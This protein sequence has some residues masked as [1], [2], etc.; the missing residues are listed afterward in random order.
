M[1]A[2]M[3]TNQKDNDIPLVFT[4]GY[5]IE[6]KPGGRAVP[7]GSLPVYVSR[8]RTWVE[9]LENRPGKNAISP[10]LAVAYASGASSFTKAPDPTTG[11]VP[12]VISPKADLGNKT[13]RQ[14][15]PEGELPP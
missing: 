15:T 9:W 4:T 8:D 10:G 11:I 12:N 14:L 13:Y 6:Y 1:T 5:R 7:L 3:N 2:D